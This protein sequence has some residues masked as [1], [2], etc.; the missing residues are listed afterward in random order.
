MFSRQASHSH[1]AVVTSISRRWDCSCWAAS[2]FAVFLSFASPAFIKP[3]RPG[4]EGICTFQDSV[5]C[6]F[7][8]RLSGDERSFEVSALRRLKCLWA[9]KNYNVQGS[10]DCLLWPQRCGFYKRRFRSDIQSLLLVSIRGW[11]QFIRLDTWIETTRRSCM[12]VTV[13][14]WMNVVAFFLRVQTSTV[15]MCDQ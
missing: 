4:S 12:N 8:C 15:S 2:A 1:I 10:S 9:F 13:W 11:D 6:F 14:A 5:P 7:W 3:G